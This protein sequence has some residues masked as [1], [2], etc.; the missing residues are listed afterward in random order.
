MYVNLRMHNND[1]YKLLENRVHHN[2]TQLQTN[3]DTCKEMQVKDLFVPE[4]TSRTIPVRCIFLGKAGIG[5][6]MLCLRIV[7][8]WL[9]GELLP[10]DIHDVFMLRLRDLTGIDECSLEDV[11]F[12][13][14]GCQKPSPEAKSLFFKQ[15]STD[16]ARVLLILDGLDEIQIAKMDT[17]VVYEYNQQV[18]SSRMIASIVNGWTIPSTRV[19]VTTRHGCSMECDKK[20]EIY[21]FTRSKMSD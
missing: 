12:T 14:Q 9:N 11:F 17:R 21:G 3:L 20:A 4:N 15:L 2:E 13:L 10:K 8:M 16:P 5:K 18:E 1:N 6:S 19:L 7:D